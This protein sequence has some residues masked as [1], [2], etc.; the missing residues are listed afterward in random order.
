MM[1]EGGIQ[2]QW[3]FFILFFTLFVIFFSV[4][5][6]VLRRVNIT[7]EVSSG[8]G[9]DVLPERDNWMS[10]F[11]NGRKMGYAH[12][13]FVRKGPGYQLT[14]TVFMRINT[15]GLVQDLQLAT[16]GDLNSD[17]SL[18]AFTFHLTSGLFQ[19]SAEGQIR[20]GQLDVQAEYGSDRRTFQIPLDRPIYLTAG[21]LDA[22]STSGLTQGET[23]VFDIFDPATMSQTSVRVTM[24][25]TEDIFVLGKKETT[26]RVILDVKGMRQTAWIDDQ[27]GILKESG[28]LGITM[29]KTLRA[30]ARKGVS[31]G[32]TED[33]TR[34]VAPVSN[35]LFEKPLELDFMELEISGIATEYLDLDGGR[36]SF[37]KGKLTIVKEKKPTGNDVEHEKIPSGIKSYLAPTAFIQSDHIRIKNVAEKIV[38]KDDS[39]AIKAEKI[40]DWVYRNIEKRPVLSLPDALSTLQNEIGDCNEHAV[41]VAAIA[42][43]AG[44]P[45]TVESGLVYMRGRFYYHAWNRLYVG[46]WVTADAVF[47]QIPADVTHI[48]L[49]TGAGEKQLDLIGVI[50][51][52][53]LKVIGYGHD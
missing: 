15:M 48:R 35:V 45:A 28:A 47:G 12:R 38:G 10:I 36:Q 13:K 19:F 3:L 44:I 21:I 49:V 42:R 40:I 43:S 5:T 8:N 52:I 6:G 30:D 41:L 4:R 2:K 37:S 50:G 17:L 32:A 33:L 14:E 1:S 29:E 25:G 39:L 11:Q 46:R 16:T 9:G 7:A 53:K 23:A 34:K 31:Q 24:D 27:G 18:A 26:Q 22:V 51:N 20:E